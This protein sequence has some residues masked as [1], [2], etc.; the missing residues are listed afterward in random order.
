MNEI[1]LKP[2]T[3]IKFHLIWIFNYLACNAVT[4]CTE[5]RETESALGISN[6]RQC[7]KCKTDQTLIRHKLNSSRYS[8]TL[9]P[10]PLNYDFGSPLFTF[11]S[12]QTYIYRRKVS[13]GTL[14]LCPPFCHS[15]IT[16]IN[17]ADYMIDCVNSRPPLSLY[18]GKLRINA[19]ITLLL[20]IIWISLC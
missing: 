16:S 8:I 13:S 9:V 19:H 18:E 20:C 14:S 4:I 5:R 6:N 11:D 3:R 2:D 12:P 17:Y 1:P 15:G 10:P 7:Q